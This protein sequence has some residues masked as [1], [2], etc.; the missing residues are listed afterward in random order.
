MRAGESTDGTEASSAPRG[1]AGQR[2]VTAPART[3]LTIDAG[4]TSGWAYWGPL[5]GEVPQSGDIRY[6]G[7]DSAFMHAL[8]E[9]Q[10]IF[11]GSK[12]D[13]VVMELTKPHYGKLGEQLQHIQRLWLVAF[14]GLD[15]IQPW[16][17]KI[18]HSRAKLPKRCH[19]QHERDA[20]RMGMW[21]RKHPEA[22]PRIPDAE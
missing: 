14:P 16:Q 2:L 9:L 5:D 21:V 13:H 11:T 4:V 22:F 8:F 19:S 12:P 7:D 10:V 6:E 20:I 15:T 3:L 1:R 17:W 18:S